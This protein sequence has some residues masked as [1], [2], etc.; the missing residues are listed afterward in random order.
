MSKDLKGIFNAITPE[1]IK[2]IPLI[3]D[4]MEIFIENL[5]ENASVA[6]SI[7]SIYDNSYDANDS[8]IVKDS[9]LNL[10][11]GLLDVY[12]SVL[13]N[14]LKTAQSNEIIKAKFDQSGI[15]EDSNSPFLKDV[16]RIISDE[17]FITNKS[18]K[19]KLGTELG[20]KYAYNLTKYLESA[21][22][23]NDLE[24]TEVKPFH[25]TSYGSVLKE[26]YENIVKPIAHPLG[27]TYDYKQI[28]D[29]SIKELFGLI[30]IY[31]VNEIEVRNVD[32]RFVVFTEE[33]DD[34][35]IKADFLL[36]F[37]PLTGNKFTEVEY[38]NQVT[39]LTN[40]V[41]DK[42]VDEVIEDRSFRSIL[43]T[44]GTYLY[45]YTNPIEILYI[46]YND[47]ILG[48]DN[49]IIDF[50]DHWSLYIDYETD[51][52]FEYTDTIEQ[53][54]IEFE[55]T[56]VAEGNDGEVAQ[57]YFNLTS[58]DYAFNV[59]GDSYP[60]YPGLDE[61]T[62]SY[63]TGVAFSAEL[64]SHFDIT[65]SGKSQWINDVT[66]TVAD[67]FGNSFDTVVTPD[68]NGDFS[69]VVNTYN[70]AGD[71]YTISGS[72]TE[73]GVDYTSYYTANGLNHND[74]NDFYLTLVEDNSHNLVNT[75]RV[76][77][78]GP[79]S[80]TFNIVVT[81]Q[82]GNDVT[83]PS[84]T[85]VGG[86]LDQVITLGA[87]QL[88]GEFTVQAT[89]F[90]GNGKPLQSLYYKSD[91]LRVA[92]TAIELKFNVTTFLGTTPNFTGLLANTAL[93]DTT[94]MG[95]HA[96]T[97]T[98]I[99]KEIGELTIPT[100]YA[101]EDGFLL[102]YMTDNGI[103]DLNNL[104]PELIL[105]GKLYLGNIYAESNDYY[106]R[107]EETFIDYGRKVTP[108]DSSDFLVVTSPDYCQEDF[109][110]YAYSTSGYYLHTDESIGDDQYLYSN[111]NFYLYTQ[112]D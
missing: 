68:G 59:G 40:K 23:T 9:K 66:F 2:S 109:L 47:F 16:E 76:T 61:S 45:Q 3:A 28:I 71:I 8:A 98:Y 55:I 78:K 102:T 34:T 41:V 73:A 100:T 89:I 20:V 53:F 42:F 14:T 21:E 86:N 83:T 15:T 56:K 84:S 11:K 112:G 65:V 27:F 32:G 111:D 72:T 38:N 75:I 54:L 70:L 90:A 51:H 24:L 92:Q 36:R 12:L 87:P 35:N 5:E 108:I 46:D 1:N 13:Y 29:E 52:E 88:Q 17:H 48:I 99:I 22:I 19:E 58:I 64:D 37:N 80:A 49:P 105:D 67:E 57:S 63:N 96:S 25:F 103:S 79:V 26:M 18:F 50:S 43:F 69:I 62:Q 106:L 44:D 107:G 30:L 81:D 101:D 93:A 95:G 94:F 4:A 110:I 31:K 85:D 39:V 91:D 7:S 77:G 6:E 10:R 74:P 33:L 82:A 104:P 60:Y 97:D